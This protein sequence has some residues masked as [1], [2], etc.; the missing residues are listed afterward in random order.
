MTKPIYF[1]SNIRAS[2]AIVKKY[3]DIF[4]LLSKADYRRVSLRIKKMKGFR[5]FSVD[6]NYSDRLLFSSIQIDGKPRLV[7]L[8]EILNHKYSRSAFL[9]NKKAMKLFI[10]NKSQSMPDLPDDLES[11]FEDHSPEEGQ[12]DFNDEIW[13]VELYNRELIVLNDTQREAVCVKSPAIISGPPG[14]GK[15][16]TALA[17]ISRANPDFDR[18]IYLS[19][20]PAL[21]SEMEENWRALPPSADAKPNRVQFLTIDELMLELDSD[22]GNKRLV[23]EEDFYEWYLSVYNK[24]KTKDPQSDLLKD[25]SL[26]YQELRIACAFKAQEYQTLGLKQTLSKKSNSQAR[27]ATILMAYQSYLKANQRI[28]LAFYEARI[29]RLCD[30][31]V[32]DEAQDL[33]RLQLKLFL[34]L[35]GKDFNVYFCMDS[36]QCLTDTLS[37]RPYLMDL[38]TKFH[39]V[40]NHIELTHSYRV[41]QK[42]LP[43]VQTVINMRH[44]ILGGVADRFEFTHFPIHCDED[45]ELGTVHWIDKPSSAQIAYLRELLNNAGVVIVTLPLFVKEA[46]ALFATQDRV[47]TPR[48]IKGLGYPIVITY[49]MLDNP[50]FRQC[51]PLL[52]DFN[53][54]N[55]QGKTSRPRADRSHPE[56][57]SPFNLLFTAITR[58]KY[59]LI[60]V[61][62]SKHILTPIINPLKSLIEP[63]PLLVH[64]EETHSSED[65][66]LKEAVRQFKYNNKL[67]A[68]T[69]FT[70]RLKKTKVEFEDFCHSM[71][72]KPEASSSSQPALNI[73]SGVEA[74]TSAPPKAL[75]APKPIASK[76]KKKSVV[77]RQQPKIMPAKPKAAVPAITPLK[78]VQA[79]QKSQPSSIQNIE[80][81][82]STPFGN[83]SSLLIQIILENNN[84]LWTSS[85]PKLQSLSPQSI[86]NIL[87]MQDAKGFSALMHAEMRKSPL[88]SGLIQLMDK[89][90]SDDIAQLLSQQS[91]EKYTVLMYGAVEKQ[92]FLVPYLPLINKLNQKQR[93]HILKILNDFNSNLLI[94]AILN[95]SP[96]TAT[97]LG[98]INQLTIKQKT[99]L[100]LMTSL[101]EQNPLHYACKE[102]PD[103]VPSLLFMMKGLTPET[104][105]PKAKQFLILSHKDRDGMPPIL[106]AAL[107]NPQLLS[108][109]YSVM[110]LLG[111]KQRA[112]LLTQHDNFGSNLLNTLV[113]K[114]EPYFSDLLKMIRPLD[115]EQ[116]WNM[117]SPTLV[118]GT[119]LI[120]QSFLNAS[121]YMSE[122]LALFDALDMDHKADL[123][124]QT[125]DQGMNLLLYCLRYKPEFAHQLLDTI[126]Q[127]SVAE[128]RETILQA[129]SYDGQ[130]NALMASFSLDFTLCSRICNLLAELSSETITSIL[131]QQTEE[132]LT[133][134]MLAIIIHPESLKL[135]LPIVAKLSE[136]QIIAVLNLYDLKASNNQDYEEKDRKPNIVFF[137]IRYRN[138]YIMDLL[139]IIK[140]LPHELQQRI[141]TERNKSNKSVADLASELKL[142]EV[143]NELQAMYMNTSIT[144]AASSTSTRFPVTPSFFKNK[145]IVTPRPR[146]L[147]D[148]KKIIPAKVPSP[149]TKIQQPQSTKR[150][151][152]HSF[153][154]PFSK[155]DSQLT[156][157]NKLAQKIERADNKTL[158]NVLIESLDKPLVMKT[159]EYFEKLMPEQKTI[160]LEQANAR[161]SNSFIGAILRNDVDILRKL[162]GSLKNLNGEQTARLLA[163]QSQE[164]VNALMF[165]LLKGKPVF[166]LVCPLFL[167]LNNRQQ[168]AVLSQYTYLKKESLLLLTAITSSP[169]LEQVITLMSLLKPKQK[170]KILLQENTAGMTAFPTIFKLQM[171]LIGILLFS[172]YDLDPKDCYE[173]LGYNT[174]HQPSALQLA[175]LLNPAYLPI[176]LDMIELMNGEQRFNLIYRMS[177]KNKNRFAKRESSFLIDAIMG[178]SPYI[179]RLCNIISQMDKKQIEMILSDTSESYKYNLLTESLF[180]SDEITGLICALT[181]QL[182]NEAILR[183]LTQKAKKINNA[184]AAAF[185]VEGNKIQYIM[186]L[187]ERLDNNELMNLLQIRAREEEC[188]ILHLGINNNPTTFMV[189]SPL[190][191]QLTPDQRYELLRQLD[192]NNDNLLMRIIEKESQLTEL[193]LE[194]MIPLSNA[195]KLDLFMQRN[196]DYHV[197]ALMMAITHNNPFLKLIFNVIKTLTEEQQFILLNETQLGESILSLAILLENPFTLDLIHLIE[198]L[199][200]PHRDS[201]LHCQTNELF[202]PLLTSMWR[203]KP[204]N[205]SIVDKLVSY[206]ESQPPEQ[207][208]DLLTLTT[209]NKE[210]ILFYLVMVD[211]IVAERVMTLIL[212]LD[213]KS[214][215]DLFMQVNKIGTNIVSSV[216][217]A[218]PEI[219]ALIIDGILTT[220]SAE[221]IYELLDYTNPDNETLLTIVISRYP[222]NIKPLMRLIHAIDT[223]NQ[224]Q[225][226]NAICPATGMNALGLA[227]FLKAADIV[228]LLEDLETSLESRESYRC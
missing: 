157:Y 50:L 83:K 168:F 169:C 121:E 120:S 12:F 90:D 130:K 62:E 180:Q 92:D 203:F 109:F 41:F 189:I 140:I 156:I 192:H 84:Q 139:G 33:S 69:I 128:T 158:F 57:I 32:I 24:S 17:L 194:L 214:K 150:K 154:L 205:V 9:G 58:A 220:L 68:E 31:L 106:Y 67:I 96:S 218:A 210:N 173:I 185:R 94:T 52:K 206:L 98:L 201:I 153:D 25:P 182:D 82:F 27:I 190:L 134:L 80:A 207:Q 148:S 39:L 56:L 101:R 195:Q 35:T 165:A 73:A 191:D 71:L 114:K 75:L 183:L 95:K 216:V 103:I 129:Y 45:S 64:L 215:I 125:C 87:K 13:P 199:E 124:I 88:R 77:A 152:S 20:N 85:K 223:E 93:Y 198:G 217:L 19:A 151:K 146:P 76:S 100:L 79:P 123:F 22:I 187:L 138:P 225:L 170:A 178:E 10:E 29:R 155:N 164:G 184:I 171:H 53:P 137:A 219:C 16:C 118:N 131:L 63:K 133:A 167:R 99:K 132:D 3:K 186:P 127:F 15:S 166:D 212:N 51:A 172:M 142:N 89:L 60:F 102:K 188:P 175:I 211:K 18:I 209:M 224:R 202:N 7:F 61:E 116:K 6:V 2:T 197:N 37:P 21:V 49:R 227:R 181:N 112:H 136:P 228:A 46:Q 8:E 141:L 34:Q 200:A 159:I 119:N 47:F 135:L 149:S 48:S 177:I 105:I 55:T 65:D 221:P 115:S 179:K 222:E 162:I 5:I 28:D 161:L 11:L 163:F 143:F 196:L 117:L 204:K 104:A 122:L 108:H 70:N 4:Q 144:Q 145:P 40:C 38:C 78:T 72:A 66:W 23:N 59:G 97:I 91:N 42:A 36:L 43:L 30:M 1:W 110:N 226:L 86:F 54:V 147:I 14:S 176:I 160:L 193:I 113:T 111:P 213:L 208:H 26:V 74:S 107:Y 81:L 44:E 126:S 174:E